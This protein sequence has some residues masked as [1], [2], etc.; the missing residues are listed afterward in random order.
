MARPY[1]LSTSRRAVNRVVAPLA[2]SGLAGR[3]HYVLA[4]RGRRTGRRYEMPA[5]PTE[6]GERWLVAPYGAVDVTPDSPIDD[7][8]RE[9]PQHPVFRL[10]PSAATEAQEARA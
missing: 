2:R 3:H 8:I 1:R 10:M 4:V 9:A 5:A 7:F 6:N